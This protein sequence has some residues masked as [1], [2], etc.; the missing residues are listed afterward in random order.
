MCTVRLG[1]RSNTPEFTSRMVAMISENSR[2]TER[3]VSK[4]SNCCE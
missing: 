2:P 3:A 1:W 4:A